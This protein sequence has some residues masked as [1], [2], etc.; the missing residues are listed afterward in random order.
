MR[1]ILGGGGIRWGWGLKALI[2]TYGSG[3]PNR[4]KNVE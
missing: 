2:V 4:K 3:K 1:S